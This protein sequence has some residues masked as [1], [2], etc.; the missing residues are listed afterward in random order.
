ME[1][2]MSSRIHGAATAQQSLTG[3]LQTYILY[4]S[5]PG[6]Y[7]DPNPNAVDVEAIARVLN[8]QVTG[9]ITDISQQNFDTLYQTV[10]L[11]SQPTIMNNPEAVLSL[12]AAGASSL[13]G[14]GFIWKFAVERA[15][16]W[17]DFKTKDPVGLFVKEFDGVMLTPDI[18]ITTVDGSATGIAKNLEITR[19][20]QYI[21]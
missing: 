9:K 8:I 17:L 21:C 3:E 10:S 4:C 18:R 14:E 7:T 2:T 1:Q 20:D 15:D 13:V 5:S 6:A 19:V 16:A 12:S 11:R